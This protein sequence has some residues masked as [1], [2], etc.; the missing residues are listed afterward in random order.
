MRKSA[1]ISSIGLGQ[2]TEPVV[3]KFDTRFSLTAFAN[4]VKDLT[5]EQRLAISR[6]GFGNLLS[7]PN[8]TLNRIFL[9]EV[10]E[11]WNSERR[12]F[13]IG[14]GE[15]GFS[16]LDVALI[17]GLPVAGHR[18]ELV[19]EELFSELEEEYGA[20]RAKR[21]VDMA[22]LEARLNSIGK[23]VSDD[24]VRSF[25]LFTIGTFLSSTDVK[26]KVDS[27]YLSFLG[28]L[29]GVSGFSWG[30]AVIEDLCQWLDKRKDNNVQCVGGCL[31]FLQTWSY[32]HFDIARPNLKDQDMTF[33]RVCR[34]DHSKSQSKK[35]GTSRFK[36]LHD[37]QIIWKL[38]PTS[39]ELK[40]KIIKEAVDLLGDNEVKRDENY[41]ASTSSNV[42]DVDAEMQLSISSKIHRDDGVDFDNQVVEDTPTRLSTCDEEYIEQNIHIE[43]LIVEE[44]PSNSSIDVEVGKE[45][46][47]Q[48]DELMV[49]DS[50]KNLS[51]SEEVDREE[52][53]YAENH[54]MEDSP[55]S[56]SIEDEVGREQECN[57]E[58]FAVDDTPPNFSFDAD[59]LRKKNI[60]LEE[61]ITELKLKISQQNE[62]NG[63]LR[64][65]NLSNIQLKKENDELK[66]KISQQNEEIGVLRGENLS[67]IQLR[68]ETDEL[69]LKISQQIEEI[70]VLRGENLS[71]IQLK[72]ETDELK[73]KISQQIEEIGVLRGENLSNIQIKKENDELKLK[74]SQQ[75]EEIGVLRGENLSNIQLKKENDELKLKISQQNEESI[76]LK[77]E[78]DELNQQV[79]ELEQNLNDIADN[80][81]GGLS[82]FQN[83]LD[84]EIS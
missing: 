25:L 47:F 61:E 26:K 3:K 56:L 28:N 75:N 79:D 65:E 58:T 17:L 52:V 51:I 34:W 37:D 30:A 53:L 18:V 35:R 44:T 4:R 54:R 74:I 68:K 48:V 40:I 8:Y 63:V 83:P 2:A 15:I 9:N 55:T 7:I 42:S 49:E 29:D 45:E 43:N 67:N 1:R 71:N 22:T 70:G 31:I 64:R 32:E 38:Q 46:Q 57:A 77:K 33:P 69:K 84:F 66:L 60:M 21:K 20:T 76:Q 73:L 11:A 82:E 13:E 50:F 36:D 41:A 39:G 24:F 81:E 78:N 6:T 14:S 19:E 62:E 12:V 16:L 10:M 59:D 72:K 27:R 23:V 80:I 5:E